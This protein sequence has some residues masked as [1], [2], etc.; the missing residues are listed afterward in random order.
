L[1]DWLA[2]QFRES[3]WDV[4]GMTRLMLT[5]AA[6]RQSARISPELAQRDPENRLLA[7]GPRLRLDAEQI[8]DNALFVSGLLNLEVGGKGVK[9]YQ[10]ANIWEPVGFAGSTTR[11]YKQDTGPALY[12]R[13]LYT[14]LKRTAPAPFMSNFDAPNREQICTGRERSNTPLQALQLMNDVQHVE[15]ARA[16][17][18]R[19][20]TQGGSTPQERITFAFRNVLARQ[21]ESQEIEILQRQLA[22]HLVKYQQDAELAKKLIT[23]GESKPNAALPPAELAA[24]TMVANA[25]LNL[26]ETVNRN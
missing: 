18:E 6:F 5:S 8:R 15:A 17:A 25:L 16:L 21:P 1:L 13:S 3:K 2:L 20:L 10:P 19:M 23:N 11:F 22:A 14:F 24:H 9:T 26:D 7:R 12:R 4:K